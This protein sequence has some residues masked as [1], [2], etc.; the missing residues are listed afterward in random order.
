MLSVIFCYL[1]LW[2]RTS[3]SPVLAWLLATPP[4]GPSHSTV[5]AKALLAIALYNVLS[6][7]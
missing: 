5:K 3:E 2:R 6:Y 4:A 7:M 1:Y